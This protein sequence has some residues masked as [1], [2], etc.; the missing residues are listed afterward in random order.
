MK[1]R[2]YF[3]KKDL[4]EFGQYI[5]SDER[6]GRKQK[7]AREHQKKGVILFVPWTQL[8]RNVTDK[9]VTEWLELKQKKENEESN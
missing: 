5:E 3:T 4:L 7:E 6:R 1:K 2:T 9:D 8:I